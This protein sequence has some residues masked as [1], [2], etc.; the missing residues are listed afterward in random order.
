MQLRDKVNSSG[1]DRASP[2][3]NI[4]ESKGRGFDHVVIL[5]TDDM[6]RWLTDRTTKLKP[7]TRAR[8]Y[9]ALTRARHSVA[10]VVDWGTAPLPEGFALYQ[11][12]ASI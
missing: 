11:R 3:M 4:G 12:P 8:F 2:A 10:I 6:R 7:Q 5:P 9:V 1:V